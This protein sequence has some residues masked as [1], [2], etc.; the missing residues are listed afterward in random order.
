MDRFVDLRTAARRAL[1]G[2]LRPLTRNLT[3]TTRSGIAAGLRRQGGLGF[4]ARA[5][6]EEERFYLGL[7][8]EG[9]VVYDVGAYEGMFSM[10]AARAIGTAGTLVI[11]EPNPR[12]LQSTRRNLELNRFGCKILIEPVA[13]GESRSR[14]IMAQPKGEPARTTFNEAIVERLKGSGEAYLTFEVEVERLG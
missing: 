10:F 8:L 9:K 11:F 7:N 6:T 3:Y 13:L 1:G 14:Q 4:L 5:V 2:I 12:N